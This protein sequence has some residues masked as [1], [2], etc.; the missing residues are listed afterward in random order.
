[1]WNNTLKEINANDQNVSSNFIADNLCD[2]RIYVD[3]GI[4]Q[5]IQNEFLSGI[6]TFNI[7]CRPIIK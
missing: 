4:Q 6:Y 5:L 2:K 3:S 7:Y 1:M